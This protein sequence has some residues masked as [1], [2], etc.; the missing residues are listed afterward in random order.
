MSRHHTAREYAAAIA[1]THGLVALAARRLGLSRQAVYNAVARHPEV[2]GALTEARAELLDLCELALFAA[3]MAGD[4]RASMFVLERLGVHR[5]WGRPKRATV[6]AVPMLTPADL[7]TMS[8]ADL[9][10]LRA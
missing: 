5:S 7:E 9:D 8:D 2:E 4:L 3:V 1:A 6:R 10:A